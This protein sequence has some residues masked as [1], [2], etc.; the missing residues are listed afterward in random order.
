MSPPEGPDIPDR[1]RRRLVHEIRNALGAI[2]TAAE[3]LE[4]RYRPEGRE[5][6]LFRAIFQEI[7][8]LDALTLA[9]LGGSAPPS[10]EKPG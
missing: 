2:R 1:E 8:R 7:D 3:L 9:E 10:P 6:R 4:R 5:E